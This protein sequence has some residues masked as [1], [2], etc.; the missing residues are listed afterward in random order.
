MDGRCSSVHHNNPLLFFQKDDLFFNVFHNTL[1]ALSD[2]D[3]PL[4]F[5]STSTGLMLTH[6]YTCLSGYVAWY[7][8]CVIL[9][10]PETH[11]RN[12]NLR[13]LTFNL[14][15]CYF[16]LAQPFFL[17]EPL[18]PHKCK[19]RDTESGTL[20]IGGIPGSLSWETKI[21]CKLYLPATKHRDLVEMADVHHEDIRKYWWKTQSTTHCWMPELPNVHFLFLSLY[22]LFF[23]FFFL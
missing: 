9:P 18:L 1:P 21:D 12:L 5:H 7:D 23:C 8:F 22:L 20:L 11:R 10:F 19:C 4:S 14:Q 17:R 16:C 2:L 15:L 6:I 13:T 3:L